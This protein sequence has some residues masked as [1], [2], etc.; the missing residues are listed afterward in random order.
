MELT[1]AAAGRLK[2]GPERELIDGYLGKLPWRVREREIEVRGKAEGA[3]L[4]AQEATKLQPLVPRGAAVIAL[5]AGG[6]N[7]T[8]E[9]LAAQ[10]GT[11]WEDGVD[12]GFVLGGADGL[13]PSLIARADLRLA[14]GAQ[15]WPHRLARLMLAEQLYRAAAILRGHP[16]HR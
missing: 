6:K 9:Q 14:F 4:R 11:W 5:D 15:T 12:A 3:E 10:L 13:D 2:R 8:S 1:L 7:L 16:Y